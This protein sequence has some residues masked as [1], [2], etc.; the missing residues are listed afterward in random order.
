MGIDATWK[1]GY[2]KPLR[3]TDDVKK[4][5]DKRWEEYWR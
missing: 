4:R 3:M 5:V 2:P 1:Q